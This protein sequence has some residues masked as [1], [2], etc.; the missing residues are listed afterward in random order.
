MNAYSFDSPVGPLCVQEEDGALIALNF[1]AGQVQQP[2]PLLLEAQRQ[3]TEYFA[4][5][6]QD[7]S[8]PLEM[9][10]TPFQKRVWQ[11]LCTIPYGQT[12]TYGQIAAQI[13]NPK[14]CRAVGMANNRN[15]IA[16]IVPC[17]RVIGSDGTLVGY[18]G[19]LHIKEALLSLERKVI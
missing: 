12:R 2:T 11:A 7:F 3:L 6:R 17:H 19:G 10:G 9:R 14:A 8:L 16:I 13:G 5:Q 15:P 1:G 4:G 18:G